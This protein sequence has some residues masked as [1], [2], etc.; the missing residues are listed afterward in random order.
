MESEKRAAEAASYLDEFSGSGLDSITNEAVATAYLGMVQPG[1]APTQ[2]GA[3]PGTWINSA[4]RE[5]YGNNVSVIPVAFKTIWS[6]RM[7]EA[8]FTTVARY[9]PNSIEVEVVPVKPGKRGYPK[10]VNPV[11]GNEIKE[12]FVYA[13]I[14]PE[15]PEAEVLILS[16][17]ASSM[18]ACKSWNSQLRSQ[19]LPNGKPAPIFAFTWNLGLEL[20]QNPN[21]P[22]NKMARIAGVQKGSL[23]DENLFTNNVK[24]QLSSVQ[25]TILSITA[26]AD[27]D[28]EESNS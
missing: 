10:M 15:H 14:L 13:V 27:S 3:E 28:T 25:R 8:P 2:E 7:N 11:S 23:V 19:L 12:L 6:E 22:A 24:P 5:N 17:T 18:R 21:Q 9:E 4:T 26:D 20:V 1:S 16:P